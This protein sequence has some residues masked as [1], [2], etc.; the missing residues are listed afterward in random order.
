MGLDMYLEGHEYTI[1]NDWDE[2][3][4]KWECFHAL[5]HW[6]KNY[7][8][9]SFIGSNFKEDDP[10]VQ[11]TY[12]DKRDLEQIIRAI[13]KGDG[14][15]RKDYYEWNDKGQDL[16]ILRHAL[17]WLADKKRGIFK[18]LRYRRSS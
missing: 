16:V 17:A 8:L 3:D 10:E 14:F 5:G 7:I 6:R 11:A 18:T 13:E 15:A 12:L 9:D 2:H 1:P 4:L